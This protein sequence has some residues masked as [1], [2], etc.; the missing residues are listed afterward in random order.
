MSVEAKARYISICRRLEHEEKLDEVE[1]G[2]E[3]Q[4]NLELNCR[5]QNRPSKP[6]PDYGQLQ[7]Q[8]KKQE[9]KVRRDDV[10]RF[11]GIFSGTERP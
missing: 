4:D 9:L 6:L 2:R 8:A 3:N 7:R 5:K 10:N 1:V 11:R